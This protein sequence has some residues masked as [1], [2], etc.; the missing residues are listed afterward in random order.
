MNDFTSGLNP[1]SSENLPILIFSAIT[2]VVLFIL[3]FFFDKHI[4][5][6]LNPDNRFVKWWKRN[7]MDE[8]PD[9]L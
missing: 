4:I 8:D 2:L 6:K 5:P 1:F 7:I 9:H 3:L